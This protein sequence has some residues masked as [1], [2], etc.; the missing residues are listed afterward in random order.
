MI[1]T[2]ALRQEQLEK[3]RQVIRHDAFSASFVPEF[4]AGADVG[5][6]ENGTITRAAIAILHYPTLKLVEY[7]IARVETA[8]PYIPGLLSFREYPALLAAWNKLDLR[9]NLVMVDGQGI[10]HPRRLGV[11]SHFGL[12]VDVP[13]IGIAKSRLC[14][15]HEPV[16]EALGSSQPLIDHDEQIGLVWRSKKRCNPLYISIGHKISIES[17][18]YWVEHCMKGYKLPEPTRWADGIASNRP[19]FKQT[20]QKNL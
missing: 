15:E 2:K 6:E 14:G 17:A 12:L 20:M 13:T 3:A 8:L 19:F 5:F 16:G 7:Q 1:D 18:I 4:I 10:A 11:A 9:P